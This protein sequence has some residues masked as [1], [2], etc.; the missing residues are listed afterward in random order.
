MVFATV[1]IFTLVLMALLMSALNFTVCSFCLLGIDLSPVYSACWIPGYH[2]TLAMNMPAD[3]PNFYLPGNILSIVL[4]FA[5][6]ANSMYKMMGIITQ[7]CS[8][9]I[10][11]SFI[12]NI[13]AAAPATKTMTT[14]SKT[15][16]SAIKTAT[17]MASSGIRVGGSVGG[18]ALP[19]AGKVIAKQT[20]DKVAGG[21]DKAGAMTNKAIDSVVED[22]GEKD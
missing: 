7:V 19:G 13:T 2:T 9:L 6:I 18:M 5:L 1:A 21:V 10:T 14:M 8:I 11:G 15:A 3:V 4:G 22:N 17:T 16:Q 12:R 20:S